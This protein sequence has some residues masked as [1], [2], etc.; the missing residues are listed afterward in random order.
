W[1]WETGAVLV[2]MTFL[3][4]IIAIMFSVDGKPLSKWKLPI[5]PSALV[6]VFSAV[7]KSSLL[8]PIAGCIGQLKWAYFE[9]PA[10]LSHMEAFDEATRGPWG[11]VSIVMIV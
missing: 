6:A 1:W 2:S 4:L 9:K 7:V 11:S 10:R 5:Q 3:S 8:V